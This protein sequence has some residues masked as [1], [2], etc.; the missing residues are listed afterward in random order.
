MVSVNPFVR[1]NTWKLEKYFQTIVTKSK[2]TPP[3]A[4]K[5]FLHSHIS[6]LKHLKTTTTDPRAITPDDFN[7]FHQQLTQ[8]SEQ[9]IEK[10]TDEASTLELFSL[11][12]ILGQYRHISKFLEKKINSDMSI[13][14]RLTVETPD[15]VYEQ[16]IDGSALVMLPLIQSLSAKIEKHQKA[17]KKEK[18]RSDKSNLPHGPVFGKPLDQLLEQQKIGFPSYK[19][20]WFLKDAIDTITLKGLRSRV[21]FFLFCFFC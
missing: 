19:I 1:A 4:G 16:A 5:A 14:I 7:F 12:E 3:A 6:I 17:N 15:Q 18:R 13:T 20:P 11:F 8:K 10:V 21:F 2:I 9:I